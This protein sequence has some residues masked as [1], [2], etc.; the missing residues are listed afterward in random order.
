VDLWVDIWAPSLG[1]GTGAATY[2]GGPTWIL[3]G[4][5]YRDA[6]PDCSET[7][8]VMVHSHGSTSIRWEMFYLM[9]FM[10]SHGWIIVAPDHAGNTFYENWGI[11]SPF[12]SRRPTDVQDAYNWLL[13][14]NADPTSP[15][16][17][18]VDEDAGYVASGY[19]FG[20]YTALV[21]GGAAATDWDGEDLVG[22]ADPRVTAIVTQAAWNAGAALTVGTADITVPTLTIGGERDSTVGTAYESMHAYIESTPR[23][24]A[25]FFDAG[26][27]SPAAIYCAA[28]GDGCGPYYMSTDV[29]E[30]IVKTSV[31]AFVEHLQGREGAWEQ[32]VEDPDAVRWETVRE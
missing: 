17:G 32:R 2:Y 4:D 15:L 24:L 29:Y 27:Y 9:E 8:P 10:A 19:S 5:G 3:S 14:Q 7:R 12:L 16:S 11:L 6:T 23:A 20:G 13:D 21:T 18:C 31:L 1:S 25:S 22:L 30:D 26:H 28:W